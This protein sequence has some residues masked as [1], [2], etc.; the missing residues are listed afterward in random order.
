MSNKKCNKKSDTTEN[1]I[2]LFCVLCFVTICVYVFLF[3]F[4]GF[5]FSFIFRDF[6]DLQLRINSKFAI[7]NILK[8]AYQ[9]TL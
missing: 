5:I 8:C 7:F 1:V 3:S 6:L 9:S 2:S 4:C